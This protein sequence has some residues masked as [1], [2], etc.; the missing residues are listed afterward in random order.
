MRGLWRRR[1]SSLTRE[2]RWI[3]SAGR[4]SQ[5]NRWVRKNTRNSLQRIKRSHL[6]IWL[7]SKKG[8]LCH[9]SK[10]GRKTFKSMQMSWPLSAKLQSK[11][12]LRRRRNEK[13]SETSSKIW[14]KML[15][16]NKPCYQKSCDLIQCLKHREW[17]RPRTFSKISQTSQSRKKKISMV[18][19]LIMKRKA[20][21]PRRVV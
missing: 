4:S 10:N 21:I 1:T 5:R 6:T 7:G 18:L 9:S 20:V 14:G 12:L 16:L 11:N 2:R 17:T 19:P 8:H 3:C 13:W 15:S